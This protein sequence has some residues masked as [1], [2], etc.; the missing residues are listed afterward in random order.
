MKLRDGFGVSLECGHPNERPGARCRLC[1]KEVSR[2]TTN[3][4]ESKADERTL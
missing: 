1:G 4:K 2:E 3:T